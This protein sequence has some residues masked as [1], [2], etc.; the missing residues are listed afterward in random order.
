MVKSAPEKR[1]LNGIGIVPIFTTSFT[2]SV[3]GGTGGIPCRFAVQLRKESFC[4]Y[5]YYKGMLFRCLHMIV[6]VKSINDLSSIP[7]IQGKT[8]KFVDFFD[9]PSKNNVGSKLT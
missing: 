6:A 8:S 4:M 7:D 2:V 5:N 3:K 1:P 9:M